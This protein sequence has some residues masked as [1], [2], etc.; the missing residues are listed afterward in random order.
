M[1][2][3]IDAMTDAPSPRRRLARLGVRILAAGVL[4]GS[5]AAVALVVMHLPGHGGKSASTDPSPGGQTAGPWGVNQPGYREIDSPLAT[6]LRRL[7]LRVTL[8]VAAGQPAGVYRGVRG[9]RVRYGSG[10]HFGVFLLTV[11]NGRY[12]L[13]ARRIRALALGCRSC[14]DNRLISLSASVRGAVAVGG[15]PSTITWREGGRT[16]EVRGPASTFSE[17][18]AIAAARAIARVNA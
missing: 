3:T 4:V 1:A 5:V 15:R 10:S 17:Q 8:P 14:S 13:R 2:V 6:A 16:F 9:I 11:S 18:R 12:G 7:P